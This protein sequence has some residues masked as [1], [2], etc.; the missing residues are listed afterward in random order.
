MTSKGTPSTAQS[1]M[2]P[3]VQVP[4]KSE[5]APYLKISP[6]PHNFVFIVVG[7]V[8]VLFALTIL[9]ARMCIHWHTNRD[10]RMLNAQLKQENKNRAN[11]GTIRKK[12]RTTY[13]PLHPNIPLQS[14]Y[15]G[16]GPDPF[17]SAV[18]LI[19]MEDKDNQDNDIEL[20]E[21]KAPDTS[22]SD[23]ATSTHSHES[24]T[25]NNTTLGHASTLSG[26]NWSTTTNVGVDM[27]QSTCVRDRDRFST[28]SNASTSRLLLKKRERVR[29]RPFSSNLGSSN[30]RPA[31][32]AAFRSSSWNSTLY[33]SPTT[34]RTVR[35]SGTTVPLPPKGDRRRS[36]AMANLGL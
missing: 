31:L 22:H 33:I 10:I 36:T 9:F 5:L 4:P 3:I 15:G 25:S 11:V 6:F 30:D 35:A 26:T 23:R 16:L 32:K 17:D 34:Y 2:Y 7:A 24:H 1:T 19:E 18:E 8:I 29:E 28:I 21:T 14:T 27:P 20:Q 12:S 13:A